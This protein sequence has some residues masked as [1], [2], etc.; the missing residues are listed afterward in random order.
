MWM[1][2]LTSPS[3]GELGAPYARRVGV[4][5][6]MVKTWPAIASPCSIR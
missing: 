2:P 6:R 3:K 4:G 5:K 1:P